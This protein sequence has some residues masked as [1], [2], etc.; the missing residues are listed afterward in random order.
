MVADVHE[1]AELRE[2]VAHQREVVPVVEVADA[3]DPVATVAVAEPAAQRVA[4]VGR[5]GDQRVVVEGVDDLLDQPRLRIDG[6]QVDVA[7]HEER[8]DFAAARRS[9]R[10]SG[11][12]AKIRLSS[13]L[14]TALA[15][16]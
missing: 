11:G 13:A 10:S 15:S 7:G 14:W 12:R 5:V 3:Q 9:R 16:G 6:M 8:Q 1:L 2:R 4:G